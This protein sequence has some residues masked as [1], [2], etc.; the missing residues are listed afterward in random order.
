MRY[1]SAKANNK[2]YRG[3]R[4]SLRCNATPAEAALWLSHQGRGVW[5][6]TA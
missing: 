4:K 1:N 5:L 3:I 6:P 2:A